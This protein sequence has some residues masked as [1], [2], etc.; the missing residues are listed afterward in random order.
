MAVLPMK[1]ISIYGL[2]DNRKKILEL[3]QQKGAVEIE[4]ENLEDLSV[5]KRTDTGQAKTKF[6]NTVKSL[7]TAVEI[8]DTVS[9]PK[10][11]MLAVLRGRAPI[12]VSQY[13]EISQKARELNKLARRIN[14]LGKKIS[15]EKAEIIRYQTTI[16]TLKPWM[17]LDI[18]MKTIGT[19]T[20][21]VFIGTLPDDYTEE[22]LKSELATLLPKVNAID[23]EVINHS[24]QQSCIFV[25]CHIKDGLEVEKA[26]RSIGLAYPVSPSRSSPT[27]KVKSLQEKIDVA[28]KA[29]NEAQEQIK[30]N[31]NKR[32]DILYSIDYYQ[33][34][35][36]KYEVLGT[37]WQSNNVFVVS[38]YIPEE[39]S[40]ELK[41]ALEKQYNCFIE[42]DNPKEKDD[43]PVK[44]KNNAFATPV[45]SVVE[46]YSMPGKK[47]LD[48]TAITAVFYY[49]LFGMMLSDAAYGLIMVIACGTLL[50]KFRNMEKG[51]KNTLQMFLYC[52][53][54][55]T[56]WGL[57]F[58]SFFG[59]VIDVVS[60]TFF[61]TLVTTPCLW[62]TPIDDPM[63]L[64]VFSFLLGII[65]LFTGL[66][67]QLYQLCKEK[68][69]LDGFYD[70]VL[71]YFLVGGAIVLLVSTEMFRDMAG[72]TFVLPT[73]VG[74]IGGGLAVVGAIGII[75]TAGRE[76]RSPFKRLLKGL[77]GLYGVSS[78]L[79][80]I[81]SYSRLLALGLATGVIA[82]VFNQ[83]GAMVGGGFIGAIVF[84]IVFIIGHSLNI[85]I[86]LLGAY[87]HT[88]RL[89]FVE[90]F[91]KF[92]KGDGR[93]FEPF[94]ANTKHF[95]IMEEK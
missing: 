20:S 58:G 90:F 60:E 33:M 38:G 2:K 18:P 51:M 69:Y 37:L 53:V 76:S 7:T 71:W 4:K 17:N 25:V 65:H 49:V 26:L 6:E 78:Y 75:L 66:G 79:S 43:V 13:E 67:V 89:Q 1:K 87:V 23:V 41:S 10:G 54:S 3:I 81:L 50:F 93:K 24:T 64:L 35:I 48:P 36:D 21:S 63:R 9:P 15:D 59:D 11:D 14:T 52:G 86:N 8:M 74:N 82:S 61:G 77:Y 57:M 88:N 42:L 83:M 55:T 29:I 84:I 91:G 16:D 95:K 70:V 56:F 73:I 40:D 44:L 46:S 5:F 30:E 12:T 39:N 22:R 19:K 85:G 28:Q 31:A 92:Y 68:K 47:E 62:Y 32:E 72:L 80:D 34:R 45:E 27:D 94:S